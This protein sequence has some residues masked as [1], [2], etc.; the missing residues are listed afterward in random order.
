MFKNIFLCFFVLITEA[1]YL[2][3][4]ICE[5]GINYC[6]KCNPVTKLCE[7]CEKEI[8]IPDN[9]GGCKGSQ[10]CV[11]RNNYC[12]ECSSDNKLCEKCENNFF[13]DENGGCSYINNCAISYKGICFKCAEDFLLVGTNIKICKYLNSEEFLNCDKINEETGLCYLCK[14]GFYLTEGDKKCI[15]SINCYESSYGICTK[16]SNSYYLDKSKDECLPKNSSWINCQQTLDGINCDIC[17]DNSYLNKEGKCLNIKYCSK[18]DQFS[19]CKECEE[20]YFLANYGNCCSKEPNCYYGDKDLG[21][22][23][24]CNDFYFI[25][26]KDGKCKPNNE[27]NDYKYCSKADGEC[28]ECITGTFL[29][30]DKKCSTSKNCAESYLGLCKYCINEYHLGRDNICNNI[31]KCIYL[32]YLNSCE[33]CEEGYYFNISSNTCQNEYEGFKNCKKTDY[34]GNNCDICRNDFYINRKDNLCYSNIE[35]NDFYKCA[36]SFGEKCD[37]CVNGYYLGSIDKKCSKIYGCEKSE[38][39]NKCLQC[40]SEIY[41]LDLKTG[42]CHSNDEINEEKDKIYFMCNYTNEEGTK[43]EKCLEGYRINDKGLCVRDDFCKEFDEGG[44]CN[45]CIEDDDAEYTFYCLN[46]DFGC[47]INYNQGCEICNN[48]TDFDYCDKCSDGYILEN[49]ECVCKE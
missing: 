5:E 1:E 26:F 8:F 15:K 37:S 19:R 25:D 42:Y 29:G 43:C 14:E 13:P 35:Q 32:N 3:S 16:C 46:S 34:S 7:K 28:Y 22:C 23:T 21:I 24:Q 36:I 4:Q 38:N 49:G 31:D 27:D 12:L 10:K 47:V 39:E 40:N 45:K 33:E 17:E 41:C 30:E 6:T 44:N 2:S 48:V 20:G 9:S 18:E 11:V